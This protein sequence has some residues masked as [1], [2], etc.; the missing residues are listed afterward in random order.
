[1]KLSLAPL[2][3]AVEL[4]VAAHTSKVLSS[5]NVSQQNCGVQRDTPL[6]EQLVMRNAGAVNLWKMV[7]GNQK[8]PAWPDQ[9]KIA[10][11][12]LIVNEWPLEGVWADWLAGQDKNKYKVVIHSK[13]GSWR[14]KHDIFN[15]SEL[16]HAVPTRWCRLADALLEGAREALKDESVV[17]V[18]TMCMRTAPVKPFEQVYSELTRT[19]V[20]TRLCIDGD[21]KN[22]GM[23][24]SYTWARRDAELFTQNTRYLHAMFAGVHNCDLEDFFVIAANIAK[25]PYQPNCVTWSGWDPKKGF[26]LTTNG[27]HYKEFLNDPLNKMATPDWCTH[28]VTVQELSEKSINSLLAD[29]EFMFARK[30]SSDYMKINSDAHNHVTLQAY[31]KQRISQ[32]AL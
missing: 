8:Q 14:P 31:L 23:P 25:R 16:H 4:I 17:Q 3:L 19:P 5:Q 27:K 2:L 29:P 10:F 30:L 32:P 7:A 26:A 13:T 1:M 12:F 24:F 21:W 18:V 6:T 22:R 11:V 20:Q 9:P 28:P 15:G